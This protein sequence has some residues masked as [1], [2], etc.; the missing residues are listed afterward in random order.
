MFNNTKVAFCYSGLRFSVL[1]VVPS[2]PSADRRI[3]AM[4]QCHCSNCTLLAC[5]LLSDAIRVVLLECVKT[6]VV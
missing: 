5:Q 6:I 3:S 1:L 4:F 2:S